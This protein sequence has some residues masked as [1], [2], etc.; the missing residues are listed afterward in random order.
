M[1]AC[2]RSQ[3]DREMKK[4]LPFNHAPLGGCFPF[5]SV[6]H[7]WVHALSGNW[8]KKK[9]TDNIYKCMQQKHNYLWNPKYK[10]GKLYSSFSLQSVKLLLQ[11]RKRKQMWKLADF[12]S[13][14][15]AKSEASKVS[16]I[17]WKEERLHSEVTPE[18]YRRYPQ[19][20]SWVLFSIYLQTFP[21]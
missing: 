18:I 1:L 4:T 5:L 8:K 3:Q 19:I 9:K 6:S 2:P 14:D 11:I 10:P 16:R 12:C 17:H 7:L 13:R 15:E 21:S 20:F